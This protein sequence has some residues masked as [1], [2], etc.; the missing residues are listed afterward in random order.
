MKTDLLTDGQ[1]SKKMNLKNKY[2][3]GLNLRR[4]E[5]SADLIAEILIENSA[6]MSGNFQNIWQLSAEFSQYSIEKVCLFIFSNFDKKSHIFHYSHR[7]IP[8]GGTY[9]HAKRVK[10]FIANFL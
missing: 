8:R 5:F 3:K 9:M 1:V 6:I 4:T 10:I 2:L 7:F